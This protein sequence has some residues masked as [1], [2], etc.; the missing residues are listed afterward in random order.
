VWTGP[1]RRPDAVTGCQAEPLHIIDLRGEAQAQ[2]AH[3]SRL[4]QSVP[5]DGA[6]D[7]PTGPRRLGEKSFA[8]GKGANVSRNPASGRVEPSPPIAIRTAS[9]SAG[10][11]TCWSS[12]RSRRRHPSNTTSASFS[13]TTR[14]GGWC[15]KSSASEKMSKTSIRSA[16][17]W[18][19]G[20]LK[21]SH[22]SPDHQL[23][24]SAKLAKRTDDEISLYEVSES[25]YDWF[26]A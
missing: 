3:A 10:S 20:R 11:F 6:R 9:H 26:S 1:R 23:P 25:Q 21:M 22:Q 2:T 5:H 4:R 17:M 19:G 18:K 16:S 8:G 12:R 15:C 13:L 14:G 7:G 24:L